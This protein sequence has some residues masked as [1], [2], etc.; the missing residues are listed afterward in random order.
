M[1]KDIKYVIIERPR[2]GGKR[3]KPG[4][5]KYDLED[6][7]PPD[8]EGSLRK[9]YGYN[10]K[11]LNDFLAP[12]EGFLRKSVGRPWD[13]VYSEICEN[14]RM[15][16]VTQRHVRSHVFGFVEKHA[17]VKD[18]IVCYFSP[19]SGYQPLRKGDLYICP[20]SGLLKVMKKKQY[21]KK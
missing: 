17:Y 1:R 2:T 12:L 7:P 21:F 11:E 4:R 20:K 16:S 8:K 15:D 3:W 19:Y 13:K 14:L 6:N 18:N 10:G 9:K 5:S